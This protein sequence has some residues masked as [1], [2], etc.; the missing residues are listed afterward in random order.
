MMVD[1]SLIEKAV[2]T[3]VIYKEILKSCLLK[4][5]TPSQ[6]SAKLMPNHERIT[7]KRMQIILLISFI[8]SQDTHANSRL[9]KIISTMERQSKQLARAS[10]SNSMCRDGKRLQ[11][12]QYQ[13]LNVQVMCEIR[14]TTI[15]SE[16]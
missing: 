10:N 6:A 12:H 16:Y 14:N 13:W 2:S 8:S 4:I 3:S 9:S 15:V 11:L 5:Q 1:D 7:S